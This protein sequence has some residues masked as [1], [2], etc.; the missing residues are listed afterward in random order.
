MRTALYG[1]GPSLM[2]AARSPRMERPK[3]MLVA[4]DS[5]AGVLALWLPLTVLDAAP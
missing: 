5:V 2:A 1:R 4:A 3:L